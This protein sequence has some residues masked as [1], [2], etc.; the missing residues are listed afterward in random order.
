[1]YR[2]FSEIPDRTERRRHPNPIPPEPNSTSIPIPENVSPTQ[3][4]KEFV[5]A[6]KT[7]RQSFF[8]KRPLG[9]LGSLNNRYWKSK[10][11]KNR[12]IPFITVDFA[13]ASNLKKGVGTGTL[14]AV[15]QLASRSVGQS[16]S[17]LGRLSS[18]PVGQL[19]SRLVGQ[20]AWLAWLA[21]RERSSTNAFF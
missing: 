14:V 16:V 8:P 17:W 19:A 18:G 21:G 3:E 12:K 6:P 4:S 11:A 9:R 10:S 5:N 1:M 20:L 7:Q 13:D 2:R 15:V